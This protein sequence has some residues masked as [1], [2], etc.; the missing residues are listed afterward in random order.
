MR[1]DYSK[2]KTKS[3]AHKV[4]VPEG[5]PQNP[6]CGNVHNQPPPPPKK[7]YR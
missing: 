5:G 7:S 3:Q 1:G 4:I 6:D 2:N